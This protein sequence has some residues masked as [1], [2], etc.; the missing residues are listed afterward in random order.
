MNNIVRILLWVVFILLITIGVLC[1]NISMSAFTNYCIFLLPMAGIRLAHN[2][3]LISIS[4]DNNNR[5]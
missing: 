1:Y 2:L 4:N 5:Q 3:L